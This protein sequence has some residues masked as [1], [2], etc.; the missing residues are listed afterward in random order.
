MSEFNWDN[1]TTDPRVISLFEQRDLIESY[2][3]AMDGSALI[4]YELE[5]LGLDK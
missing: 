2:I 5:R 3:K 1:V 4:K